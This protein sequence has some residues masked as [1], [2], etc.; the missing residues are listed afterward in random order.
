[1]K[2]LFK[3]YKICGILRNVPKEL[4]VNYVQSIYDGGIRLFEVAMNSAEASQQIRELHSLFGENAYVGAGTVIN[5]DRCCKAKEAGASFFLTPSIN[6]EVLKFCVNQAMPVLPG[7]FTPTDV[8]VCL[9]YGIHTMKLFP[10]GDLPARYIKSLK[11]P[12]DSTEYV[13]VGGVN[14]E[15]A[16]R[17]L[18]AGYLGVG[19]GSS[20]VPQ[21]LFEERDW[22]GVTR[23]VRQ[24]VDACR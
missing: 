18:E 17:F 24:L 22:H 13:A 9:S 23:A 6:E 10:A 21:N 5:L 14:A 4:F 11:G 1:M 12:F 2:E 15:N 8:S 3:K 7:V 20:L 16:P 19:I